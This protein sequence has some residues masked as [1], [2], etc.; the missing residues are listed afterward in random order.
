MSDN[1]PA[2]LTDLHKDA[3]GAKD[4]VE[5]YRNYIAL[6]NR[7]YR[8]LEKVK[9][10]VRV[11]D[12][13]LAKVRDE[14]IFV[15]RHA[16]KVE[17][18]LAA[19][20]Q[21]YAD[22]NKVMRT[23]DDMVLAYPVEYVYDV[24]RL[25]IWRLGRPVGWSF[26]WLHS[27]DRLEAASVYEMAVL[28]ALAQMLPDQRDYITLRRDRI[29]ERFDKARKTATDQRQALAA[30]EAAIPKWTEEL[31]SAAHALRQSEVEKLSQEE[32]EVRRQLLG[33]N[34]APAMAPVPKAANAR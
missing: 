32:R 9:R 15:Q 30:I 17:A 25:G 3:V 28:P 7:G 4:R 12:G 6:M 19:M 10:R 24:C 5:T 34:L 23:L 11:L 33:S 26:L 13:E 14:H 31:K 29:D 1:L 27:Q 22:P 16:L 21:C 8:T 18:A 20:R 2:S